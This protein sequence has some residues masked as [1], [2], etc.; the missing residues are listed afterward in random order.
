MECENL[1]RID[2]G[3]GLTHIDVSSLAGIGAEEIVLPR[4]LKRIEARGI[5]GENLERIVYYGTERDWNG[6]W[7]GAWSR[8]Y[9]ESRLVLIPLEDSNTS[10]PPTDNNASDTP[11]ES[12][13]KGVISGGTGA[14]LLCGAALTLITKKKRRS[15]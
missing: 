11:D 10:A 3:N 9:V 12:G 5:V 2:L 4:S 6:V 7:F 14:L 15:L 8:D 13:C 1:T